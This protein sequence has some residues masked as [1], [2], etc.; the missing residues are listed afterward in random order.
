MNELLETLEIVQRVIDEPLQWGAAD[1][2]QWKGCSVPTVKRRVM[3]ARNLGCHV[4][5]LKVGTRWVYHVGN[6]SQVRPR[7]ALWIDLERRRFG[8]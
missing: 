1:V 4:E 3:D 2:A 7:L 6:A 8:A 5:S